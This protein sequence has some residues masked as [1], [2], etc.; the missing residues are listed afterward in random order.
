VGSDPA[1]TVTAELRAASASLAAAGNSS[2]RVDAEL[3][4][5]HLLGCSRSGLVLA[6]PLTEQQSA[7]YRALIDRRA[8]GVPLQHLTGSAPF[9]HL[10]LAV[11][12]GVF[13]PRP[14]TEL[15]VELAAAALA[16]AATVVDLGAGSGAIAL[17]VAHEFPGAR[18]VA[19]ERSAPAL[20][21]LRRNAHDRASAGDRPVEVVPGDVTA[22][23]VLAELDA[24]VDVVLSNPPYVPEALRAE[25]DREVGH[26]PDDAVYAGPDGLALMPAV[27]G[28]AARLLRPGGLLVFEH[29]SGHWPAVAG[30]LAA[31]P[32]W[33]AAARHRD[34]TGRPRFT[35]AVRA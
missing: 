27:L 14:E 24:S 10:E 29:D 31:D 4:L 30:L 26:D 5:A 35:S 8:A 15:I 13:I 18:V 33:R 12:P 32:S 3:L 1:R 2:P 25:L 22:P 23:T 16:G 28:T 34:L 17:S 19:L 21:W 6:A 20:A 11:G 9:R 7:G